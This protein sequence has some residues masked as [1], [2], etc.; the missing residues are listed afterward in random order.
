[1][2]LKPELTMT[3]NIITHQQFHSQPSSIHSNLPTINQI[4][5]TSPHR[6]NPNHQLTSQFKP[7]PCFA[8]QARASFNY[9]LLQAPNP[10]ACSI[11]QSSTQFR[12]RSSSPLICSHAATQSPTA[13]VVSTSR[14]RALCPHVICQ[15]RAPPASQPAPP[16]FLKPVLDS[17]FTKP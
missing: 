16:L 3:C 15:P 13:G 2:K 8:P 4:H 5:L 1:M 9:H 11:A 7:S 12:R 14:A 10:Q 17:P 6:E